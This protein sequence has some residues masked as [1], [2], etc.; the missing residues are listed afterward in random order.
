MSDSSEISE[1]FLLTIVGRGVPS[2]LEVELQEG[3]HQ[4]FGRSPRRGISI[5]WDTAISRE[6]GDLCVRDGL[7]HVKCHD[8][9][10]NSIFHADSEVRA[11]T[12]RSGQSFQIGSTRFQFGTPDTSEESSETTVQTAED[13][14]SSEHSYTGEDLRTIAFRNSD[15]QIEILASLPELISRTQSDHEL[16]ATI[17][18]LLM[19]AISKALAVAVIQYDADLIPKPDESLDAFPAPVNIEVRT[20]GVDENKFR[21]SR[22]IIR[23]VLTEHTSVLHIWHPKEFG[24][25][26]TLT[27]GLGWALCAPIRNPSSRGWCLYV[28]GRG[29][30]AGSS[31]LSKDELAPQLRFIELVAQFIGSVHQ[32]RRLQQRQTQLSSFFSPRILENLGGATGTELRP[33]EREITVLFCDLRGF[34]RMSE[35]SRH[36]LLTLLDNVRTALGAMVEGIMNHGG[37]VADFQGDAALGF[38]GWPVAEAEGAVPACRAALEI[39]H[40]FSECDPDGPLAGISA[41][42]GIAHGQAVAGEVGTALQSK[43]G[44]FG[45]VVNQG[46]RL[47]GLTRQFGVSICLDAA[48][49]ESVRTHMPSV[50][51]RR[52][53]KIR[54][55]GMTEAVEVYTVLDE[56]DLFVDR[57]TAWEA[58]LAQV[59]S[60]QWNDARRALEEWPAED[61]PARFLSSQLSQ[62]GETPPSKWDG[63]LSARS[64]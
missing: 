5:P 15:Q 32:V 39:C 40:A 38:W 10:R 64:K 60:G 19:N 58:L 37:A 4:R 34:S 9:A 27:A 25:Q 46:A 14:D 20:R 24:D 2:R 49:A 57:L 12:V 13:A 17:C 16:Q 7:L 61:G 59:E 42:V 26:F 28:S 22:G 18:E 33:A 52:L 55:S 1:P 41:G 8:N 23:R 54:P 51:L 35:Q 43:I 3:I 44:V 45:P 48:S 6:H 62:M 53:A 21:P 36:S 11:A 31:F 29:K 63:V 56:D 47:E 50:T 30:L